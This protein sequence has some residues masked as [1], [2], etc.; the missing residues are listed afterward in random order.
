VTR[1][2]DVLILVAGLWTQFDLAAA[3]LDFG[4]SASYL[5]PS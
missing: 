5:T 4:R 1:P 2:N 3:I